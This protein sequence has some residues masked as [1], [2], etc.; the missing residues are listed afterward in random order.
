MG[1]SH[2]ACYC[3]K[4]RGGGNEGVSHAAYYIKM[5]GNEGVSHAACYCIKMRGGM[6]G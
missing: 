3:I 5:R 2:A 6:R 1:V 4:M